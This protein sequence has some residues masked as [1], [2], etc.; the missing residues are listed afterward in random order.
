MS[1]VTHHDEFEPRGIRFSGLEKNR[2]GG[3]VV[4]L[5]L[6]EVTSS[7]RQRITIQTPVVALPFGVTPYQEA[8]TGEIQSYSVDMSFNGYD[9]AGSPIARFLD[10]MRALDETILDA[11]VA[12]SKEWFGKQM[13][14]EIVAEFYRKLVRDPSDPKYSPVMRTKVQLNNGEP[15][16]LFFG[17]DRQPRTIDYV[18]KRSSVMMI[19]E[20]DRLWF[21][22]KNFGCTWRVL[23]LKVCSKPRH[24]EGY[25]FQDDDGDADGAVDADMPDELLA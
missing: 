25:S 10:K 4:Y 1:R 15:A 6:N 24:L 14:R 21:V 5:S 12:N 17:E 20:L 23:Q 19:L 2:K 3:K 13:S 22:N 8:S 7:A 18:T 16:A 11:A 9:V